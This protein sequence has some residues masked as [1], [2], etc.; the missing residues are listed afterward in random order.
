MSIYFILFLVKLVVASNWLYRIRL[1]FLTIL[2]V[3]SQNSTI[4][5]AA[6]IFHMEHISVPV[7]NKE[8]I[9]KPRS[10]L[11]TF[12]VPWLATPKTT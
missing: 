4:S 2:H 7:F 12:H 5:R 8:N 11:Q 1:K 10:R 9:G 3:L 6:A